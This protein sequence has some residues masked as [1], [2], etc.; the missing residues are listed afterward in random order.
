M[1][2]IVN[3]TTSFG[4]DDTHLDIWTQHRYTRPLMTIENCL[5]LTY[6]PSG[7]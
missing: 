3:S 7:S 1:T 5:T 6:P 4:Q 2:E